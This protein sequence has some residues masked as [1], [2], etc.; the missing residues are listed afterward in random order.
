MRECRLPARR[1]T[2]IFVA[3]VPRKE[4]VG[5]AV[6]DPGDCRNSGSRGGR[7]RGGRPALRRRRW[8]WRWHLLIGH[9]RAASHACYTVAVPGWAWLSR[10]KQQATTANSGAW[11][12]AAV[13]SL[14]RTCTRQIVQC[15]STPS[16]RLDS[17]QVQHARAAGD[18]VPEQSRNGCCTIIDPPVRT[19][20]GAVSTGHRNTS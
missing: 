3:V 19:L 12:P 16:R 9:D 18:Q 4:A 17:R 13:D 7:D 1:S 6:E 5:N 2:M 11:R 14:A 20:I 8:D 15:A 10:P